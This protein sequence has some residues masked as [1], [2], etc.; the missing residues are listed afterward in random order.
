MDARHNAVAGLVRDLGFLLRWDL[1]TSRHDA[2]LVVAVRDAPTERHFDP[3]LIRYWRTD[4]RARGRHAELTIDTH[5]PTLRSFSWGPIE[6]EDRFGIANAFVSFGGTLEGWSPEPGTMIVT[7]RSPGPIL[8]RGGHSQTYDRFAAEL[9]AFF[10]RMMVPID[11][12]AGAE[13]AISEASPLV[14][15][16]AFLQHELAR[17]A[18]GNG[19]AEAYGADARLVRSEAARIQAV[20]PGAWRDGGELL[21]RIGL[22]REPVRTAW[23]TSATG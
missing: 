8:R 21:Q 14:R 16:A 17:L 13:H 23:R 12:A 20:A 11:F 1:P 6:I 9:L 22:A 2:L 5:L 4:T 10:A 7:F 18:H 19:V 3:E 15:Y